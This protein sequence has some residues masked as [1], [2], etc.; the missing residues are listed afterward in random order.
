MHGRNYRELS[1][2]ARNGRSAPW[3]LFLLLI[4]SAL[5]AFAFLLLFTF[6]QGSPITSSLIEA[7][8]AIIVKPQNTLSEQHIAQMNELMRGGTV[9]TAD[10]FLDHTTSFYETLI[11]VLVTLLGLVAGTAYMYIKSVSADTASEQA[12]KYSL[13]SFET[14]KFRLKIDEKLAPHIENLSDAF[15]TQ[16]ALQHL[17]KISDDLPSLKIKIEALEQQIKA[18]SNKIAKSDLSEEQ[19]PATTLLEE[20]L[21]STLD[22]EPTSVQ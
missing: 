21:S 16:A 18:I 22:N 19:I 12:K 11:T 10:Q 2:T 4:G 3:T 20:P 6:W 7:H 8:G 5:G 17:E 15:D 9:L 13:E 1:M 14:D